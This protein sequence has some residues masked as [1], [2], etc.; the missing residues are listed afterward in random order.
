MN[1]QQRLS[2]IM[3]ELSINKSLTLKDIIDLTNTSRDT[4]RR[5][6][7]KLSENDLVVRNYGGISLRDA[8][9]KID[10][11]QDRNTYLPKEKKKI[12]EKAAAI[13]SNNQQIYLDVST[14]IEILP[15]F[16]A[17]KTELNIVTNSID[18]ADQ[19]LKLTDCSTTLLGGR[20]NK[21]TRAMTDGLSIMQLKKYVFDVAILS[22]AGITENGI[23][24]AHQ[25]DIAMKELI[26]EQ[27][28]QVYILCDD[29]KI[30]TTH[31]YLVYSLDDIDRIITNHELPG[32]I[33]QKIKSKI[34]YSNKG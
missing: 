3:E 22:C 14:T 1:Q 11:Y 30:D 26:R 12:A 28:K 7:V 34:I 8:F 5:D 31:N 27:S 10:H 32:A 25:E 4:A 15:Q 6:I 16:L 2:L 21:S 23:Y 13:I 20:I 29:S 33:V 17:E 24:Y 9:N 19:L 18:I